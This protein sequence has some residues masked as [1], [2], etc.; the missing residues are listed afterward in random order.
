MFAFV[1]MSCKKEALKTDPPNEQILQAATNVY[2]QV[3]AGQADCSEA[4]MGKVRLKVA[5]DST[6]SSSGAFTLNINSR[7][8]KLY[9]SGGYIL[10]YDLARISSII[11]L[12]YV[13]VN[14]ACGN[15]AAAALLPA[16]SQPKISNLTPGSYPISIKVNGLNNTGV[17]NVSSTGTPS[18]VMASSNGIIVE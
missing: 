15:P 14:A 3:S 6:Q 4:I 7:T 16:M 8:E 11:N 12:E 10:V 2:E 9:N 17:L 5:L 13:K 18:L 1:L